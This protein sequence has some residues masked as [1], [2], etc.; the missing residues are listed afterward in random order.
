MLIKERLLAKKADYEEE[1]RKDDVNFWRT[2]NDLPHDTNNRT[3]GASRVDNFNPKYREYAG[4][5]DPGELPGDSAFQPLKRD[6]VYNLWLNSTPETDFFK[7]NPKNRGPSIAND[8]KT[9]NSGALAGR[10]I[11]YR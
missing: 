4:A 6:N 10:K 3:Y 11:G 5:S 1:V 2:S 9:G 7:N 8:S